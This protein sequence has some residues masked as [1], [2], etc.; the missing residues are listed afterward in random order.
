MLDIHSPLSALGTSADDRRKE[1]AWE[2]KSTGDRPSG[3]EGV[4]GA[5]GE[6]F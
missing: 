4:I 5:G 1:C 6:V 2:R 3:G